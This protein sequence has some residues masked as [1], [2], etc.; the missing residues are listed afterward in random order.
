MEMLLF[1]QLKSSFKNS[2]FLIEKAFSCF[3]FMRGVDMK[4]TVLNF[5]L[6]AATVLWGNALVMAD[7]SI[8]DTFSTRTG[9]DLGTTEA[10]GAIYNW[11]ESDLDGN[12]NVYIDETWGVMG[13]V[14]WSTACATIDGLSLDLFTQK[15]D[16][17]V[18]FSM[19]GTGEAIIEYMKNG[20]TYPFTCATYFVGIH[21]SGVIYLKRNDSGNMVDL[22]R[23][24]NL[25]LSKAWDTRD[26][27]K[28]HAEMTSPGVVKTKVYHNDVEIINCTDSSINARA[29]GTIAFANYGGYV[30]NV[31]YDNLEINVSDVVATEPVCGDDAH[32]KPLGDLNGDCYVNFEDFAEMASSWLVCTNPKPP[33]SYLP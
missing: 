16:I 13:C 14:G 1:L 12:Q 29:F 18:Y 2:V 27:L 6:V 10:P 28:I 33:C 3:M 19:V 15:V 24:E 21:P 7:F 22:G 31:I 25:T 8:I 5:A 32:P 11:L 26:K 30:T 4:K 17:T 20:T 23:V 9:T